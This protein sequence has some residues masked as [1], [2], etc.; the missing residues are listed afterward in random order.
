MQLSHRVP[1]GQWPAADRQ[2]GVVAKKFLQ[3]HPAAC[4]KHCFFQPRIT[5]PGHNPAKLHYPLGGAGMQLGMDGTFARQDQ[6]QSQRPGI[7]QIELL[8]H[9]RC[10]WFRTP[11]GPPG[12][13][14]ISAHRVQAPPPR[15]RP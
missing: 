14:S 10:W 9:I 6:P 13:Q 3:A 8:L 1:A 15:W 2:R 5:G 11:A 12:R 7:R 4:L